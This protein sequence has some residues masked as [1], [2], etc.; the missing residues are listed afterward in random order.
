MGFLGSFISSV[1]SVVSSAVKAVGQVV[2]D[3]SKEF[4]KMSIETLKVVTEVL[5]VIAK[6]MG[7]LSP[8]ETIEELGDR[9]LSADKKIEDFDTTKEYI[10]YLRGEIRAKSIDE[11]RSLPAEERLARRVVGNSIVSKAIEEEYSLD[12][13]VEF[14][15]RVTEARLGGQEINEILKRFKSNDIE[16]KDFVEYLK[17]ELSREEE[18]RVDS[19][20][21]DT[22]R[23]LEPESD[24]KHIEEKILSMQRA[25]G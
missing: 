17:R 5:E 12:I 20:L 19:F 9:A 16:P 23:E 15:D 1:V 14:W 2:L 8:I 24:P 10:E 7:I 22:Y 13:P 25:K 18:D 3:K 4:L 21:V 11:L 6:S